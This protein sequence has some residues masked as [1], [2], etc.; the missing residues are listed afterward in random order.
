MMANVPVVIP[1]ENLF[2][3]FFF[4]RFARHRRVVSTA[5]VY[6]CILVFMPNCVASN[7]QSFVFSIQSLLPITFYLLYVYLRICILPPC[8]NIEDLL[9]LFSCC[10]CMMDYFYA[11]MIC[12]ILIS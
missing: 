3:L 4:Q 5:A 2:S 12:V 7:E 10:R 6:P 9:L 8:H 1:F 11:V